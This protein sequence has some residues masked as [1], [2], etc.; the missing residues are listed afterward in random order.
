M[1]CASCTAE[2]EH[3][4]GTLVIHFDG[5]AECTDHRCSDLDDL[6]H[7]LII[8]CHSVDGR[9]ECVEFFHFEALPRA[10]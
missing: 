9:C 10:S 4:H 7:A 3:C 5:R 1:E 6:R 2:L 8:D